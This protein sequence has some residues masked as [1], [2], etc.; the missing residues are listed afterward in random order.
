MTAAQ[1]PAGEIL[2]GFRGRDFFDAA[3][4]THFAFEVVPVKYQR[5]T[6]IGGQFAGLAAQV[7]GIKHE[8]VGI[9]A[10]Q[11]HDAGR[12]CIV[13]ADGGQRH[14]IDHRQ[15]GAH[16]LVEPAL[17]LLERI[18]GDIGFVEALAHV[19]AAQ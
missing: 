12:G 14:C 11:Q 1:R 13:G 18:R 19:I 3:V 10:F 6:R 8:T 5:R 7:V 9:D 2:V 15:F 17:E 4:D 16:R